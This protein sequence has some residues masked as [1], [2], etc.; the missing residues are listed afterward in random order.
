MESATLAAINGWF[1]RFVGGFT[2]ESAADQRNYDLKVE[3]TQRVCTIMRRIAAAEGLSPAAMRLA[4]AVAICHDVGRFPQ[5]QRYRTFND[6]TSVN[7]GALAVHT[8]KE[9]KILDG[10]LRA[11]RELLLHAVAL[12]NV[13]SLPSGLSPE[14]ELLTKLIRD[15]D[16]LDIWRVLIEYCTAPAEQQ[17]TA[18]VWELP[19]T[20]ECSLAVIGEITA[21]RMVDRALLRTADDFK[22]LQLSWVFDLNFRESIAILEEADYIEILAGLLPDQPACQRA[23]EVVRKY[24]ANRGGFSA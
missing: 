4:E 14:L 10:M 2:G 13:F 24:V 23:V 11:E 7:H 1:T 9:Q 20:G 8:L 15:A 19:T 21:G 5:Y 17:A 6:A 16:K 12:H 3:H 22:L 18:V